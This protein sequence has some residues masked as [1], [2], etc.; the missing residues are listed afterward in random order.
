MEGNLK[1][2]F[3]LMEVLRRNVELPRR[4]KY[5][6]ICLLNVMFMGQWFHM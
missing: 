5:L 3:S 6:D 2:A 4:K 1:Q